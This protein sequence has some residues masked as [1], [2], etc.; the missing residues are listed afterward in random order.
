MLSPVTVN[1]DSTGSA[2]VI[3]SVL[4]SS[5]NDV[6]VDVTLLTATANTFYSWAVKFRSPV[7]N[8]PN[9]IIDTTGISSAGV[10]ASVTVLE[11]GDS[12]TLWFDP[13]PTWMLEI[14][15]TWSS[16]N[17]VR[18]NVEVYIKKPTESGTDVLK[19]VCDGSG[20]QGGGF[21]GFAKGNEKNCGFSYALNNTALVYSSHVTG[22]A[23]NN[24]AFVSITGIGFS[25][26]ANNNTKLSVVI[27]N[28]PC[29]IVNNTDYEI[30]CSIYSVPA[31]TYEPIVNVPGLGYALDAVNSSVT[32]IQQVF[33]VSQKGTSIAG[34]GMLEIIGRGFQVPSK[35]E[36]LSNAHPTMTPTVA[37]YSPNRSIKPTLLP[38]AVPSFVPSNIPSIKPSYGPST[39]FSSSSLPTFSPSSKPTFKPTQIPTYK[40]TFVPTFAPNNSKLPSISPSRTPTLVPT[41][42]TVVP[43]IVP[44][45]TPTFAPS[46]SKFITTCLP[47]TS[48]TSKIECRLPALPSSY[49]PLISGSL[50]GLKAFGI[51]LN[52]IPLINFPNLIYSIHDTPVVNNIVPSKLSFANTMNLLIEGNNF[53]NTT[54]VMVGTSSCKLNNVTNSTI[55]CQ[56]LRDRNVSLDYL[57][58]VTIDVKDKG[59]AANSQSL[60]QLPTIERG[61]HVTNL[62]THHGSYYGGNVLSISGVGF[63]ETNKSKYQVTLIDQ[64]TGV[65][66]I[67]LNEVLKLLGQPAIGNQYVSCDVVYISYS[68]I[69]CTLP[70]FVSTNIAVTINTFVTTID[71]KYK[72]V[73]SANGVNSL[74]YDPQH[75]DNAAVNSTV[76]TY[77][78]STFSTPIINTVTETAISVNNEVSVTLHGNF[79]S[80]ASTNDVTVWIGSEVCTVLSV[81]ASLIS[82]KSP[83]LTAGLQNITLL[84]HNVGYANSDL[85]VAVGLAIYHMKAVYS[86]TVAV[87]AS[88]GGGLVAKLVGAGFNATSC[89]SNIITLT[90]DNAYTSVTTADGIAYVISCTESVIYFELPSVANIISSSSSFSRILKVAVTV[91][92]LKTYFSNF[93]WYYSVDATPIVQLSSVSGYAGK[94]LTA[95]VPTTSKLALNT[96][97]LLMQFEETNCNNMSAVAYSTNVTVHC[98]IP[99]L[100]AGYHNVYLYFSPF[101]YALVKNYRLSLPKFQSLL[102][103][104]P[105]SLQST[106]PTGGKIISIQGKGFSDATNVEVVNVTVCGVI[107]P[108]ISSSYNTLK[109]TLPTYYTTTVV[110]D[111][112]TLGKSIIIIIL[113]ILLF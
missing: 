77:Q 41:K 29:S 19:A 46:Y 53:I 18:S 64:S 3:K 5:S 59:F 81:T 20:T 102:S 55:N 34:G 24:T 56:L 80:A 22:Y 6:V 52:G 63:T 35:I 45:R 27:N 33:S 58:T 99:F 26:T 88:I 95:T 40:P 71:A 2:A 98:T 61:F 70:H 44:T 4:E 104:Q 83:P 47:M 25:K 73:V 89:N 72:V 74:C 7:G 17:Q 39:V 1:Y 76:C 65:D 85:Q 62:S 91:G 43:T 9:I 48:T 107:C 13:V 42:P 97:N 31:G 51:L 86:D 113:F 12:K 103:V 32:F 94:I 23:A 60:I 87:N 36:F 78:Q 21:V 90:V 49:L 111:I 84:V 106:N 75:V 108:I 37:S 101:G 92:S 38:T 68:M 16:N 57:Q 10:T 14:P 79:L 54:S 28:I 112:F 11:Q 100:S 66:I 82:V 15:L 110:N 69:N 109:C 8:V 50:D 96:T 30:I 105:L 93:L 67:S